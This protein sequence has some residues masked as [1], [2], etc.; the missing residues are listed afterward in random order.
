MNTGVKNLIFEAEQRAKMWA[1]VT[2]FHLYIRRLVQTLHE[3][4]F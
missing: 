2:S 4:T 1:S 3:N